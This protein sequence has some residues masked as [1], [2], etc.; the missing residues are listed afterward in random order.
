MGALWGGATLFLFPRSLCSV[1]KHPDGDGSNDQTGYTGYLCL[2]L[3]GVS[4]SI[5]HLKCIEAAV[6]EATGDLPL[7][8]AV[9]AAL[10]SADDCSAGK[11]AARLI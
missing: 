6:T 11:L 10:R 2:P 7:P 5:K 9:A 4:P 3:G 1:L 8:H